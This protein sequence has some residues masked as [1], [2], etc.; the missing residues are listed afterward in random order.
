M[1]LGNELG[2]AGNPAGLCRPRGVFRK[3]NYKYVPQEARLDFMGAWDARYS[4]A[5]SFDV[6]SVCARRSNRQPSWRGAR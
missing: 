2:V 4:R 3:R 1:T 5:I 6:P